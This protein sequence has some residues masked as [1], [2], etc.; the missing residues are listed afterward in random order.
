MSYGRVWQVSASCL[1]VKFSAGSSVR[2][3]IKKRTCDAAHTQRTTEALTGH[4]SSTHLNLIA[5]IRIE[6][7][8]QIDPKPG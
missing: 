5:S 8:T 7:P 6:P 1:D 3:H 2:H 4:M